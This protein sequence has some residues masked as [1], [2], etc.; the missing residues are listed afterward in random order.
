MAFDPKSFINEILQGTTLDETKKAVLLEAASD[1]SLSTKFQNLYEGNLRQDEFSRKMNDYDTKLKTV[2]TYWQGLVKWKEDEEKRFNEELQNARKQL[3]PLD[4][5]EGGANQSKYVEELTRKFDELKNEVSSSSTNLF[6]YSNKLASLTAKHLKE[7]D[8]ALDVD[9]LVSFSNEQGLNISQAYD[10]FVASQRDSINKKQWDE[11]LKKA[12]ED[13]AAEALKNA[14]VPISSSPFAS[15]TIH[16]ADA[17]KK[18][19]RSEFGAMAAAKSFMD[20]F[21]AGKVSE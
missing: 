10:K 17:M 18:A 3:S 19:D 1:P 2:Q 7:F 6:H 9:K 16:A 4:D 8:E 13:G 20:D 12:R 5:H 15:G 14:N 21:R 11:Q